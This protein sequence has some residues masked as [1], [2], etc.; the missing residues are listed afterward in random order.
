[1]NTNNNVRCRVFI[2]GMAAEKAL[3]QNFG[4]STGIE[5]CGNLT[6]KYFVIAYC[7]VSTYLENTKVWMLNVNYLVFE[8]NTI[9]A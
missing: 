8:E 6:L 1:M 2:T 7:K 3:G 9:R 4:I 5:W